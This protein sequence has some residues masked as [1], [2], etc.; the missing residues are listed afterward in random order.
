MTLQGKLSDVT[1]V[2]SVPTAEHAEP[3]LLRRLCDG[4]CPVPSK[5]DDT[6]R[7]HNDP[8]TSVFPPKT[9]GHKLKLT[10]Q[11]L[12][13]MIN[14]QEVGPKIVNLSPSMSLQRVHGSHVGPK[15]AQVNT[16]TVP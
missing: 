16:R 13:I 14:S 11:E 5:I 10:R 9:L 12:I 7:T 3:V 1:D 4:L 8:A 2:H 15:H 6:V